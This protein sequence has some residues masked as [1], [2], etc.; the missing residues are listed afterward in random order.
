MSYVTPA[1]LADGNDAL[2]ELSELYGTEP[3][4]LAAVIAG[5]DTS[6]WLPADVAAAQDVLASIGRFCDQGTGEVDARLRVRGYTPPMDPVQFPVLVVW[7]R[8]ITRYHLHRQRDRT[9]EETGRIERDY[10][11]AIRALDLIA[12]GKL[13]L[14]AGD[15]LALDP[16]APDGGAV[17]ITSQP[18]A[19]TRTTLEG[20]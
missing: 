9:T 4:L 13:S 18:R 16:A 17:R 1:N 6:A 15:P 7:A 14:G 11:D 20:L 8:A 5:G 3:A 10:R 2:R 19:F 12:E